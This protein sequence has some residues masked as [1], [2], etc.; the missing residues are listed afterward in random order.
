MVVNFFGY[1]AECVTKEKIAVQFSILPNHRP[2]GVNAGNSKSQCKKPHG[3]YNDFAK[4]RRDKC[5][6]GEDHSIKAI[7]T[8]SDHGKD[9]NYHG[10]LIEEDRKLA[11]DKP[12]GSIDDPFEAKHRHTEH[13]GHVQSDHQIGNGHVN[14][15]KIHRGPHALVLSH[16]GDNHGVSNQRYDDYEAIWK[17]TSHFDGH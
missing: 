16:N 3:C 5:S 2:H 9:R 14:N 10:C 6:Q 13:S 15:V 1:L 7:K 11:E 17:N 12:G 4:S 8:D